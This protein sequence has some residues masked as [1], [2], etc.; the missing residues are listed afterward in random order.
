MKVGIDADWA[1][2]LSD[3]EIRAADVLTTGFTGVTMGFSQRSSAAWLGLTQC[4]KAA[5]LFIGS[6]PRPITLRSFTEVTH[7]E[8]RI[9]GCHSAEDLVNFTALIII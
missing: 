7:G 5:W 3:N 2:A 4:A 8:G 1:A 9:L 6:T